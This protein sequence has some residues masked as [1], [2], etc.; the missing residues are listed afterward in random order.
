MADTG[1]VSGTHPPSPETPQVPQLRPRELFWRDIQP[2][3]QEQG[4]MLRP[5]YRPRWKPSFT[6][7]DDVYDFEDGAPIIND[8]V[9]DATRMSTNELVMLKRVS[10]KVHPHEVEL[11]RYFSEEPLRSDPRNHCVHLLDVLDVPD[12]PDFKIMVFPL[13]RTYNNPKFETIGEA[14]EFFR[15]VFEGLNFMHQCHVAHR[16][17]GRLNI[18]MDPQP[19]FPKMYHPRYT[20]YSRDFKGAAK[21]HSRTARPVRY[22]L[23]DLG[24]S[25][26]YDPE[27]TSPREPPILGG[28]KSVPEF[29]DGTE[30]L[31]PFPTDVYYVGNVIRLDFMTVYVGL[32]FMNPLVDDMVQTDPLKRPTMDAV[33]SHFSEIYHNLPP[34]TLWSR[35]VAKRE[36]T[37]RFIVFQRNVGHTIRTL[38]HILL[39]R[40][41]MPTAS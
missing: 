18:M 23:I 29:K 15:Q 30:P 12:H 3:L 2:W 33:V 4:Y 32:E 35:L 39:R 25:R 21:Y 6:L 1:D 7:D 5:R 37:N 10:Q 26:R 28:D 14:L 9:L 40:K 20:N 8:A 31:D 24:L 27:N 41:P 34:S 38:I 22:Y 11:T 16:D 19:M 13:L 17:C 36:T